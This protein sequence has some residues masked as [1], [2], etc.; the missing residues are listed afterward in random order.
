MPETRIASRT[1]NMALKSI[2]SINVSWQS[3]V[4]RRMWPVCGPLLLQLRQETC[5]ILG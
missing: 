4:L 1:I 2:D 5:V 3:P